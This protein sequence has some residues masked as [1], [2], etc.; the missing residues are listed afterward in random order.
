MTNNAVESTLSADE[1]GL[2]AQPVTVGES[3]SMAQQE[4]VQA[5]VAIIDKRR[6]GTLT[7][8][9]ASLQLFGLLPGDT[10]SGALAHYIDQLSEI[11]RSHAVALLRG[12][13]ARPARQGGEASDD[14][15]EG[16]NEHG[17]PIPC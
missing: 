8:S 10:A 2:T 17:A 12:S 16:S 5:C 4:L 3:I 7:T 11:E 15:V 14:T 6:A 9:Q 1:P 13:T